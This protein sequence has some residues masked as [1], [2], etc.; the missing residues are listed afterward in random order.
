M[1]RPPSIGLVI[2]DMD[3]VIFEGEN[4]WLDLHRAMGT[5]ADAWRLW[6]AYGRT[7]YTRVSDETVGKV[8]RGRSADLFHELIRARRYVE[9]VPALFGWLRKNGIR[10]AIVSSGPYQLAERAQRDLQIERILANRVQITEGNFAG[11]VEI[12]VDDN[13]KDRGALQL[14]KEMDF[15]AARTAMIGD[16]MADVRIASVTALAI[17]YNPQDAAMS[18]KVHTV[19]PAGHLADAAKVIAAWRPDCQITGLSDLGSRLKTS[20]PQSEDCTS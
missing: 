19:L 11:T 12:M 7:D 13:H 1:E 15:P 17:A 14:M 3:G 4:F 18:A 10:T 20:R 6:T 9:G 8:W 2:F 16:S 5:E